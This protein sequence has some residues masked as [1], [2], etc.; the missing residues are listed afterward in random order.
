MLDVPTY[1]VMHFVTI[2][3]VLC[4]KDAEPIP[5][6]FEAFC[7]AYLDWFYPNPDVNWNFHNPTV[8]RCFKY[9]IK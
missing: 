2:L 9:V 4:E 1:M 3:A 6:A 5:E 7:N 8:T